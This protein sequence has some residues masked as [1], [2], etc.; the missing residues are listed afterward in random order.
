MDKKMLAA[1]E[2]QVSA[3]KKKKMPMKKMSIKGMMKCPECGMMI[4]KK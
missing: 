3:M 1:R 2:M 4:A